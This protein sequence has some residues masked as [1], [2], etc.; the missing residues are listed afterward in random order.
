MKTT[1]W[2]F[3]TITALFIILTISCGCDRY[4]FTPLE[5][6]S[7]TAT[8][9]GFSEENSDQTQPVDPTPPSEEDELETVPVQPNSTIVGLDGGHFDLD[10]A[11][12]VYPFYHGKTNHHEHEYDDKHDVKEVDFFNLLNGSFTEVSERIAL[13]QEFVVIVANAE[14]S[15]GV[16]IEINDESMLATE[17]QKRVRLFEN[18]DTSALQTFSLYDL[19]NLK[20]KFSSINLMDNIL[21]ATSTK[22]VVSN[23]PG[24]HGEYRNG[25]FLIQIL[26]KNLAKISSQYHSALPDGGLLWEATLFW[27]RDSQ[28]Q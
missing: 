6:T 13:A 16:I 25:A 11:S 18:G 22:C 27:H 5:D 21:V 10:T 17:Y 1:Q 3:K 2:N 4:K 7:P 20:V 15:P 14:L 28:C 24:A 26:D 12:Q 9:A 8:E 19:K 23:V